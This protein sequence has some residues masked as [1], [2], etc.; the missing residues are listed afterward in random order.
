MAIPE[1]QL[2]TW[3]HQGSVTQSAA[4]YESI[5]NV[6]NSPNSPYFGKDFSIFLQGSYG[7]STNVY[8]DS[9]VDIV[10]RLNQTYYSDTS[11]LTPVAK[12]NYDMAFTKASYQYA[13]FKRD[14]LAWLVKNYGSDVVPG[15]KAIAIKG[16]GSRRDADVLVCSR[17]RYY[18]PSS[19]GVDSD[20]HEGIIFWT[21]DGTEIVNFP[22]QHRENCTTKHQNTST[23]FKPLVRV[24]KNMRNSMVDERHL[25]DGVAPSYF[26]EGMLW[27]APNSLFGPSLQQSWADTYNWIK[28]TNQTELMCANSIHYLVRD[29]HRVCWPSANF[30]AYLV[31][32]VKYWNEWGN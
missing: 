26:L 21:S 17:H 6:L 12:G 2:V 5:R 15:K 28:D 22:E 29:G 25:G 10:I 14:V 13:D 3:S 23:R 27:N 11:E 32:A 16:N 4:T 7:N 9:D 8:R 31:A 18:R 19:S 24:Y 1:S 30:R 20:Y